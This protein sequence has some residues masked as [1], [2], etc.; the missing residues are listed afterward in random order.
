VATLDK[1][2]FS[3]IF[4]PLFDALH[5]NCSVGELF[6][7]FAAIQITDKHIFSKF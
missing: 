5:A 2:D 4:I 3:W 1:L 6:L 7:T